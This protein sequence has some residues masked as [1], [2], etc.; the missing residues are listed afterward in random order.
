MKVQVDRGMHRGGTWVTCGARA[1]LSPVYEGIGSGEPAS[2]LLVE[3]DPGDAYLVEELLASRATEFTVVWVRSLAEALELVGPTTDCVLL[4]LGLPDTDGLDGLR[5]ILALE[6][7]P[8]VVVL[9]G[10]DDRSTGARALAF[11]AQDYLSKG[12]VDDETL[13]RSLRYAIARRQ[14]EE[15][16]RALREAELL[17]AENSRLERGLLPRPLILNP[18]LYW[19][20]RYEPGGRRALLGGDFF[21]AV[22]LDDGTVRVLIGD[23]SGHGPDEAA[24]GVALRVAWRALVI[25]GQTPEA[26]LTA[27]ERVLEAERV[28]DEKFATVCDIELEPGLKRAHLRL[29]GHPSPLLFDGSAVVGIQVDTRSRMLGAQG[30]G[31]W[32]PTT[33]EL[34]DRWT[35]VAFTDGIV[36]GRVGE[37]NDRLES[38]GLAELAADAIQQATTLGSMADFLIT[39]AERANGAPLSDDVALILLSTA[40]R[41][42]R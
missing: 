4:D 15:S 7:S 29:G 19:S 30:G 6:A 3:D 35:L 12:A 10:F 9:T 26:T 13:A 34:G 22:E 33:I 41:W 20:T 42:N 38:G 11:G 17:R 24:L 37:G 40:P 21:D 36:E 16:S 8:A 28:G 31:S 18:D 23:V 32:S 2:I 1:N 27:L 39:G 25:A 5:S 14:G